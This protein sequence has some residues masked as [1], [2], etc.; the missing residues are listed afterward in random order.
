MDKVSDYLFGFGD[1]IRFIWPWKTALGYTYMVLDLH[2]TT[3]FGYLRSS[4]NEND[5]FGCNGNS[6][7]TESKKYQFYYGFCVWGCVC[8]CVWV[9]DR[10]ELF[11]KS[12]MKINLNDEILI[13]R[14][15]IYSSD[16]CAWHITWH[17]HILS[18]YKHYCVNSNNG[19]Q[20]LTSY[21]INLE[22]PLH[23]CTLPMTAD[24][25]MHEHL[26]HILRIYSSSEC[27]MLSQHLRKKKTKYSS[28]DENVIGTE[29]DDR[30][31]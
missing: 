19:I 7:F 28:I 18:T 23:S 17:I 6:Y 25:C 9:R 26:R 20:W 5:I 8:V 10:F 4:L 11:H 27:F 16:W 1:D 13:N 3:L 15:R 14:H 29:C 24:C 22:F 2:K 31:I 30:I 12:T 21:K